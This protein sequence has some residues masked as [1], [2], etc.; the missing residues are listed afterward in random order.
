MPHDDERDVHGGCYCGNVRFRSPGTTAALLAGYCHCLACRQAHAA[1]IY[2]VAWLPTSDLSIIATVRPRYITATT[3]LSATSASPQPA[4]FPRCSTTNPWSGVRVG[5][6]VFI[7]TAR[8]ASLTSPI[9]TMGYLSCLRVQP[10]SRLSVDV[11]LRAGTARKRSPFPLRWAEH[12]VA[13]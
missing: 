4:Y 7:C 2:A 13:A 9:S 1:P 11:V 10:K 6:H 5:C 12:K 8:K 3:V